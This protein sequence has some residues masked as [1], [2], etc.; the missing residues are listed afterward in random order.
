MIWLAA[1]S[2]VDEETS[3]PIY[4]PRRKVSTVLN[5]HPKKTCSFCCHFT[6]CIFSAGRGPLASSLGFL[7]Y[8]SCGIL[9]K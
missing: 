6:L 8:M 3:L 9:R 7:D 5:H 1:L 4:V 2:L